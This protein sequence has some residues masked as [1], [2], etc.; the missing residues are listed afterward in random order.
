MIFKCE[1]HGHCSSIKIG[2]NLKQMALKNEKLSSLVAIVYEGIPGDK[3]SRIRFTFS[4][5]EAKKYNIPVPG[6][7]IR[8][9]LELEY[10]PEDPFDRAVKD[11]S[12]MCYECFKDLYSNQLIEM[13][14][15]YD[16][17]E[18]LYL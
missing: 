3:S 2:N 12:V 1:K 13:E 16:E 18:E 7:I 8:F 9:N 6:V 15:R 11:T 14:N 4:P 17:F 5:D 10:D